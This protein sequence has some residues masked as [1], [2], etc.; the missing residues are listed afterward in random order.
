MPR[1]TPGPSSGSP[2]YVRASTRLPEITVKAVILGV[3]LSA[4]LGAA[5]AYL[6][7][8]AGMTV[9]A[10]IPA[11]VISM[12]V[13]RLFRQ[14][15]ILENNIVQTAASAG[16]SLA[17][18]VIFTIPALL[19]LGVWQRFNYWETTLIAALGG[20][21][22]V[23]FTIPLRRALIV[24]RPLQ[25]PEGV[26]TAEVLKVGDQGG[27]GI[28]HLAS[29]S[30][31]GAL[32][33]LCQGGFAIF[34]GSIAGA[35]YV[36]GTIVAMAA[37]L[38][39][40]LVGVGYII[41][42][43]ISTLVL[44]GGLINFAVAIPIVAAQHGVDPT[45]PAFDAAMDLWS[46]ETRY[47]GVGAMVIGGLWALVQLR[48]SLVSGVR[49]SLAAYRALRAGGQAAI[50]RTERDTPMTWV[51]ALVVVSLLP[52]FAIVYLLTGS[53]ALAAFLAFLM[54]VAGFLFSAVAGYMAGLVGSSN[55]PIS[56][57]TIAT[58]LSTSL[59]LLLLLGAK[60]PAGPASAIFI[61]V[62][63][64]CAAAIA[65][66]NLQDLKAG[67]LLGATPIKQQIMQCVGVVTAAL[68]IAPV[69]NLLLDAYGI[70]P[71]TVEHPHSLAAPQATLMQSVAAG[72]FGGGLP[73]GI[74]IAGMFIAVF[75]IILDLYLERRESSFRTPVLAV[76]V[77]IYLPLEL[78][79]TIFF[80]GLIAWLGQRALTRA[81]AS[82]KTKAQRGREG[83]LFAAG[84]ITGEALLGI[85]LAIPIV[86]TKDASP[87]AIHGVSA[88]MAAWLGSAAFAGVLLWLYRLAASRRPV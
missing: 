27:A 80:G 10:S 69:L 65:G 15:N 18:G 81:G 28:R 40:A 36:G 56:G 31:I 26:A 9:S 21:L 63:V 68:V 30:V 58:I 78:S 75:I 76:A 53:V 14:Y 11:A 25:Y 74:V 19:L 45:I 51:M 13:L 34:A 47:L 59:L 33:K 85:L 57:V 12:A 70:G 87:W 1:D 84:L 88:S 22:G 82:A 29:A 46:A 39:P 50:E 54:L 79:T 38:S 41:G 66:D 2:P 4:I 61:G 24:E 35:R 42:L 5:N 83:L 73:W 3:L 37:D 49:S 86:L 64:A 16:E 6:G 48:S 8:F 67:H 55:N 77:G 72:V 52:L 60:D 20:L 23:M 71:A 44:L 32:F 17:A 7:L 62:V 43:N